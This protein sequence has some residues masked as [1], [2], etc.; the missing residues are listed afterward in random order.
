MRNAPF[1][2]IVV[3]EC[4][5]DNDKQLVAMVVTEIHVHNV[6]SQGEKSGSR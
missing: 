6:C 5:L 4:T 1:G 3:M 2:E